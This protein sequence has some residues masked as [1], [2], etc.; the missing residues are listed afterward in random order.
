MRFRFDPFTLDTGTRQLLRGGDPVHLS[1]KAFDLLTM[2]VENRPW[3]LG[4]NDLHARIWPGTFVSDT[5]LSTLVNEIRTALDDS[6]R[7][8]KFLRTVHGHGYAFCGSAEALTG[9]GDA[10]AAAAWV[11][12]EGRDIPLA[13]GVNLLGRGADSAVR[14]DRPEISR[15][16]ASI[17]VAG[18]RATLEDLSSRNGTFVGDDPVTTPRLLHDGDEIRLGTVA[19]TFHIASYGGTTK[20]LPSRGAQF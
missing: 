5:S 17:V 4:K 8:P 12:W 14:I 7:R 13:E 15:R 19:L 1:P 18:A 20:A 2:L 9:G 3:A 6:A 11:R 10:G 16:H